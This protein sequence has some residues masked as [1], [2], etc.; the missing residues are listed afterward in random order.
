MAKQARI[1]ILAV[2]GCL[3]ASV[4]IFLSVDYAKNSDFR[5]AAEWHKIHGNVILVEGHK[6]N[7]P[8]GWWE[9]NEIGNGKYAITKASRSLSKIYSSGI[10]F[11]RKGPNESKAGEAQIRKTLESFVESEKKGTPGPVS[12]LI[13]VRAKSTNIYCLQS[14]VLDRSVVLRCNVVGTPIVISSVGPPSTEKEIESILST[15]E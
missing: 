4:S 9:E 13:V 7:V 6:L 14:S 12:S 10:I 2:I 11:D 15:F 5:K 1:L 8:E 3:V